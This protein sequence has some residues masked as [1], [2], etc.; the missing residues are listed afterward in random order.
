MELVNSQFVDVVI[1]G[2]SIIVKI[3]AGALKGQIELPFIALLKELAK[4]SDNAIDDV[5]V[6]L[7]EKALA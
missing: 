5:L 6:E 3:E 2:K 4:K 7:V 1:E